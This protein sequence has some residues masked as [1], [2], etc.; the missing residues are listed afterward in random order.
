LNSI[1][2]KFL[3]PNLLL[4]FLTPPFSWAEDGITEKEILVGMSIPQ[5]G[6]N[7]EIGILTKEGA[8]VYF[9]RVNAAGGIGGRKIKLIAYDDGYEPAKAIENTHRFL[10]EEKVFALFEYLGSPISAAV[11][12]IVTRA[13]IPYFAPITGAG[14]VRNPNNRYIF[15]LRVSLAE[16]IEVMVERLTQ[17]LHIRN[18]GIFVQNDALGEAGRSG[19]IRAL[20]KRNL[21]LVGDGKYERNTLNVDAALDTLVKANPQAVI[22]I[23]PHAPC[24]VLLKKAKEHGFTP[25]FLAFSLGPNALIREAGKAAEGVIVTQTVPNPTDSSLPIIKEYLS[26]MKAARLAPNL[27][28]LE[29]YLGAKV[30]VE[31]LKRTVPLTREA[32]IATLENFKMDA[33]GLEVSYRPTDHQGLHQVFLTKIENGK[34]VSIQT[35]K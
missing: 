33:G 12:P 10:E 21:R 13:R 4:L 8:T 1:L 9:D 35:L 20:K 24:A 31:A 28:S 22:M 15:S 3:I 26:E 32:F 34:V 27:V 17:D 7:S 11:V 16:E 25:I 2:K 5:S 14:F 23:A 18:I 29:G 30:L 6:L 19:A